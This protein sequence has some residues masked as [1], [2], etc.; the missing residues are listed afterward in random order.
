LR[1][2][3]SSAIASALSRIA[4]QSPTAT[5]TSSS[6]ASTCA[7]SCACSAASATRSISKCI[8]DSAVPVSPPKLCS[9]PAAS[10]RTASTGWIT[11]WICNRAEIT[12]LTVSTR[13]GMSSVTICSQPRPA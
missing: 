5:R 7:I 11:A 4:A 10:R 9:L 12:M 2:G 3:S 6:A 8:T 1:C 13:N